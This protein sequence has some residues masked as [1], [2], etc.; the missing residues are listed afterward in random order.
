MT[1]SAAVIGTVT[2]HPQ[3]DGVTRVVVVG[4]VGAAVAARLAAI[5]EQALR[6]APDRLE[7]DLSQVGPVSPAGVAVIARCLTLGQRL[8]RGVGVSVAT[9]AGRRALLDATAQV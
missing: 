4:P 5:C 9:P 6:S 1:T 2:A 8:S 3:G 7:L